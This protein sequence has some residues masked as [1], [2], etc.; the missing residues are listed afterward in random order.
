[1]RKFFKRYKVI[2][3]EKI[4]HSFLFNADSIGFCLY[5][6]HLPYV[7]TSSFSK[8]LKGNEILKWIV[9]KRKPFCKAFYRKLFFHRSVDVIPQRRRHSKNFFSIFIMMNAVVHPKCLKKIFRWLKSM[10]HVVNG[11]IS[12]VAY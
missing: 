7:F 8:N 2:C 9:F 5:I 4:N 1:M 6:S 10:H 11:K 3:Y 12:C